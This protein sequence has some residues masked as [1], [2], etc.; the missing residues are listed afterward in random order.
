M[1][2]LVLELGDKLEVGPVV[3]ELVA[4]SVVDVVSGRNFSPFAFFPD[5]DVFHDLSSADD[6][7]AVSLGC[8]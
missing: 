4:V 8:D 3:V 7:S 1:D 5:V 2:A 6:D